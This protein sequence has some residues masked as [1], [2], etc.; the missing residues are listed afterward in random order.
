MVFMLAQFYLKE[1]LSGRDEALERLNDQI[2][3]LAEMLS[4]ERAAGDELRSTVAQLSSELQTSLTDR[5][6]LSSRLSSV[7]AERDAMAASL[8]EMTGRMQAVEDRAAQLSSSLDEMTEM[9]RSA[10]ARAD[11]VAKELEDAFKVIDADKE[12]IEANLKEI[13]E[14]SKALETL[15]LARQ[16]LETRLKEELERRTTVEGELESREITIKELAAQAESR[17]AELTEVKRLSIEQQKRVD[18]LNRQ[19]AAL[20]KQ[21]ARLSVTLE[22]AEA[23]VE[24]KRVQVVDLG[25]RLNLA[26][27]SK[28]EELARYRS[29]FFGRL[30]EILGS[31]QDVR[32]VGDRFVF[33]SEVLFPSGSAELQ[34]AGQEQLA[35]FAGTLREISANIPDDIDWILRVDGHTD[36]LPIKTSQFP[37][38]WELSAARAISVV[39]FLR[40]EGI[41]PERL[42]ATGFAHFRPLDDRDDEIAHRRNRRIEM[43]LTQR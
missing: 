2:N 18:L 1:A 4:L 31:R 29:E 20:R 6:D 28:V 36:R 23:E 13:A 42:A 10:A 9:A 32:V 40:A 12:K 8:A 30:R 15:R 24:E 7:T 35:Q 22:V 21:I 27:A 3:E 37:S 43:K 19:L 11:R 34:V 26:L 16:E 14:L 39:R 17:I 25:K 5:D 38:N 33:Q 41:A